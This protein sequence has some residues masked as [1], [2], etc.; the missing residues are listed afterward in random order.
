MITLMSDV[1]I[2][3]FIILIFSVVLHELGHG[4]AALKLGDPT[5]S[6]MG[7]LTLN[8]IPHIDLFYTIIL[9]FLLAFSGSPVI[10]G[11]AK[12]VPVQPHLFT[13]VSPR[14][15]MMIVAAAG[16]AVNFVLAVFG[17]ALLH[18]MPR[19]LSPICFTAAYLL[20]IINSMLGMFNL[21]PIP[22]LD[23]SKVLAGILPR[24][25]AHS[26]MSIERYGLFILLGVMFTGIHIPL[27]SAGFGFIHFFI[28]TDI[29]PSLWALLSS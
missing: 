9:P 21:L 15:G 11:G 3:T 25:I 4:Y 6:R 18:L 12:P 10:L 8:P 28:P 7:R 19:S 29:L 22:P 2:I 17:I 14:K 27:L 5:A 1:K 24:E 23:G 26:Y 20:T 16:P 13:H